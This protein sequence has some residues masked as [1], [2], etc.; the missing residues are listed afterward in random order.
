MV[1]RVS[2]GTAMHLGLKKG[3]AL[4]EPTTAYVM[5]PG[6]TCRGGCPYCPQSQGDAKWLSRVTWPEYDID[7]VVDKIEGSDLERICL[8]SPDVE[9]YEEKIKDRVEKLKETGKPIS[10]STPPLSQETLEDLSQYIDKVGIGLDSVTDEI[11]DK[12]KPKY[13]PKVYW[14]YLGRAADVYGSENVTVHIIVGMGETL[15]EFAAVVNKVNSLGSKVSLFSYLYENDAPDIE[16][17]RRAQILK[18]MIQDEK[19]DPDK[20]FEILQNR[21]EKLEEIIGNGHMFR[22]QGCPGCN[23]PYYT[24]RPG[25]EHRNFPRLPDEEELVE[26]KKELNII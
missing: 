17:Y 1:I 3:Q 18:Y 12:T 22:T 24:T 11:R 19:K 16:Y 13:D 4:E 23:R 20:A 2:S 6:D 21:P 26:I 14:E 15:E 9:G 8:Q 10:L 25:E 5:I 7:T